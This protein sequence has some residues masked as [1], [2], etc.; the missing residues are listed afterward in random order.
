MEKRSIEHFD[1]E[2]LNNFPLI[3]ISNYQMFHI[4]GLMEWTTYEDQKVI[5]LSFICGQLC[6][7]LNASIQQIWLTD[8]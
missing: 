1:F 4:N 6:S 2:I 3:E 7:S 8:S 5:I